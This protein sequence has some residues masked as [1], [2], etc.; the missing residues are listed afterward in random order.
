MS[1]GF[2]VFFSVF[3]MYVYVPIEIYSLD[4]WFLKKKSNNLIAVFPFKKY[5]SRH[6]VLYFLTIAEHLLYVSMI[7]KNLD[8][9]IYLAIPLLVVI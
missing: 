3:H 8:I 1:L 5:V 9:I 4:V 6:R 2:E 7:K